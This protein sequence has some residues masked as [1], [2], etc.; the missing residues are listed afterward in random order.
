MVVASLGGFVWPEVLGNSIAAV[1]LPYVR[2]IQGAF[3]W[4]IKA[5]TQQSIGLVQAVGLQSI[6]ARCINTRAVIFD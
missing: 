6:V 3:V 5:I 1:D 2:N 4:Q